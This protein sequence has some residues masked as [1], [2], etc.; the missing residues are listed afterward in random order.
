MTNEAIF[1]FLH[2][3][4][5]LTH[6]LD[7]TSIPTWMVVI[8]RIL[9]YITRAKWLSE[10]Y[11][12]YWKLRW[13]QTTQYRYLCFQERKQ[14]SYRRKLICWSWK[15]SLLSIA[16]L[17]RNKI[18]I[19]NTYIVSMKFGSAVT[20]HPDISHLDGGLITNKGLSYLSSSYHDSFWLLN[21]A[22]ELQ[23]QR[24]K[25]KLYISQELFQKRCRFKYIGK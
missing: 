16:K 21:M 14:T 19:V 18:D 12:P 2:N 24:V 10:L 23:V 13:S 4:Q 3:R 1:S 17:S 25:K 8:K 15:V 11:P 7:S 9:D 5:Y 6:I 20:L 22:T